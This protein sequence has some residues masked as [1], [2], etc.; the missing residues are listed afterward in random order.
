MLDERNNRWFSTDLISLIINDN[1]SK[2][3]NTLAKTVGLSLSL[4]K[5]SVEKLAKAP[6]RR[7]IISNKIFI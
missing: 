6:S 3:I 2:R 5:S 1:Y 4:T 7:K